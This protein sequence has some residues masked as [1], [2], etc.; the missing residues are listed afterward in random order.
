ML[1]AW[2]P[3][4]TSLRER[5]IG[6][7]VI[8]GVE[9]EGMLAS[10]D[11]LDL[12]RDHSGLLEIFDAQPGQPLPGVR[13]DWIIEID[14]KSLTHRP[15]LW[16]HYGMA[17]EVAAIAHRPLIDPVAAIPGLSGVFTH[18]RSNCGPRALPPIQRAGHGE[19][20]SCGFAAG[21]GRRVCKA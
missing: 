11:E 10:A 2:V 19:R 13:P 18:R 4:G 20:Y 12:S 8:E 1:A 16:G 15:D 3:P 14:N 6:T 5:A 7:A 9:S 21:I 17:R